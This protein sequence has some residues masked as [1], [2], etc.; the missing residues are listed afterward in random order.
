MPANLL[1]TNI[2]YNTSLQ[3]SNEFRSKTNRYCGMTRLHLIARHLK[4]TDT[5]YR[6]AAAAP[7][8]SLDTSPSVLLLQCPL[9]RSLGL[10]A[11]LAATT[12]CNCV[13]SPGCWS[14]PQ[15]YY[16]SFNWYEVNDVWKNNRFVWQGTL[17]SM[18]IKYVSFS[19]GKR[20]TEISM[21]LLYFFFL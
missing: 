4:G 18:K 16:R 3:P 20:L 6:P 12:T 15:H 13:R 8:S 21:D 5:S 7:W 17:L 9:C 1:T 2:S 10:E 11:A 14:V 19:C